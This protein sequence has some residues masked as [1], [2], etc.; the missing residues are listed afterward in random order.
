VRG[1][2]FSRTTRRL[3]VTMFLL[4]AYVLPLTSCGTLP[5]LR[6]KIDV[7]RES[8]AIFVGGSGMS[9][10]LYAVRANGG[11]VFQ[12]TFTTVA[13]LRPALAPNGT[14]VAFLRGL[15]LRDSTPASPVPTPSRSPLRS[16]QP[17]NPLS[18]CCSA[19]RCSPG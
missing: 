3:A 15:S 4:T 17:P 16:A 12:F 19:T 2:N 9:G 8:Y 6:D 1:E 18:Q 10:D 14:D 11:P 5:P 13:E 7:G